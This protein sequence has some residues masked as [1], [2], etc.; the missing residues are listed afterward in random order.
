MLIQVEVS[1]N[2]YKADLRCLP[3]Y[4][5][6]SQILSNS[7]ELTPTLVAFFEI[8]L[9]AFISLSHCLENNKLLI[10]IYN[11]YKE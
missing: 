8:S 7:Q 3:F 5:I 1:R 10:C 4:F 2:G 9:S 6:P 11:G